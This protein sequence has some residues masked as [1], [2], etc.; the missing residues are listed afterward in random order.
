VQSGWAQVNS[1]IDN[2][3]QIRRDDQDQKLGSGSYSTV[4]KGTD[5]DTNKVW[6]L[7]EMQKSNIK[8]EEASARPAVAHPRVCAAPRGLCGGRRFARSL[9]PRRPFVRTVSTD[10]NCTST[11]AKS[12]PI[13]PNYAVGSNL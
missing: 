3:Y 9:R 11:A 2:G 7:K 10:G 12:R 1:S 5:R 6:A 8:K 13:R 4:W